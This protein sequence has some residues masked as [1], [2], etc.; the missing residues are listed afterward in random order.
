MAA[1]RD[2][3]PDGRAARYEFR[4]WGKHRKARRAL[5]RLADE[6][7]S[8]TVDDCYL[9]VDDPTWNAKVRDD[10]LKLK[11]LVAEDRG[12]ERW[13]SQH[14][15]SSSTTPT[16]FDEIFEALRLDRPQRGKSF[17][18]TKAVKRLDGSDVRAVFVV[19]R[20]RRFRVGELRAEATDIEL[21]DSGEVLHTLSIEGDDLDALRALRKQLGLRDEPNVAVHQ[22][23]DSA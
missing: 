3:V 6:E 5:A 2:A 16:P 18:I 14:H 9:L 23:I 22:A 19:K 12:F 10:T 20:R 21:T 1:E 11:H 8:E 17:D 4:V 7:T 13:S 15:R